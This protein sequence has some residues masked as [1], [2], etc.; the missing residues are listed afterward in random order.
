MT[1]RVV[2][3]ELPRAS[4]AT[5]ELAMRVSVA[6][7]VEPELLRAM[8]LHT[9]PAID[10]GAEAD[11]WF[12]RLVGTRGAD[13]LVLLPRVRAQLHRRLSVHI[14]RGPVERY[15]WIWD[16]LERVHSLSSPALLLE[17]RVTWLSVR[18]G[19]GDSD[20]IETELRRALR[21]VIGGRRT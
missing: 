7:R 4:P 9:P 17:E 8:R 13:G 12:S 14:A 20:A 21:A 5:V 11:L 19:P 3:P 18:D 15:D 1:T 16:V 6:V 2:A 10:V